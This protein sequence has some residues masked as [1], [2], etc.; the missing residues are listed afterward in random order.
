MER[1]N[2][3]FIKIVSYLLF[4]VMVGISIGVSAGEIGAASTIS[5]PIINTTEVSLTSEAHVS[6]QSIWV[7]VA[8]LIGFIAMSYRK[9]I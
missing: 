6:L 7:L 9:G 5:S 1:K 3:N 4:F 8:C 2:S